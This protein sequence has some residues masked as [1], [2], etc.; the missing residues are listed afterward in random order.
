MINVYWPLKLALNTSSQVEPILFNL[1]T[2]FLD[3]IELGQ[4]FELRSTTLPGNRFFTVLV[5]GFYNKSVL[6][7]PESS[8]IADEVTEIFLSSH[9]REDYRKLSTSEYFS[10]YPEELIILYNGVIP[11]WW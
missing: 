10:L 7:Q 3:S 6:V 1:G 2:T 4:K 9:R 8:N 11:D 5:T